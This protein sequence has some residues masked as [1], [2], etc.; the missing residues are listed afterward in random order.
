MEL[1]VLGLAI[2]GVVGA[3]FEYIVMPNVML[4]FAY[5]FVDLGKINLASSTSGR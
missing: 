2:G 5:Q 3:G 1:F 4:T